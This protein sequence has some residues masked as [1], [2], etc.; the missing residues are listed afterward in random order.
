MST[1]T[2]AEEKRAVGEGVAMPEGS[3]DEN[4]K[5]LDARKQSTFFFLLFF[6]RRMTIDAY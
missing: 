3:E 1:D 5:L 2:L 6:Y 4:V